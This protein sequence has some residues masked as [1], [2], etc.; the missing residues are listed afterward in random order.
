MFRTEQIDCSGSPNIP[1]HT[2]EEGEG[3]GRFDG[4]SGANIHMRTDLN[5][6]SD[7]V[8]ASKL[9]SHPQKLRC[10][11]K[12]QKD[13]LHKLKCDVTQGATGRVREQEKDLLFFFYGG[14]KIDVSHAKLIIEKD[15]SL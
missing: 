15:T 11:G 3:E 13:V 4:E 2:E 10:D 14:N 9:L 6:E 7:P 5:L 8:F 1:A 12:L